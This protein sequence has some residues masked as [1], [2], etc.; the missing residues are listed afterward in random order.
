MVVG[1]C[2]QSKVIALEGL[3]SE[4]RRNEDEYVTYLLLG[5][6]RAEAA[7][8]HFRRALS[9]L[10]KPAIGSIGAMGLVWR[11]GM[12]TGQNLGG[13]DPW[14]AVKCPIAIM[15]SVFTSITPTN[16]LGLWLG[17]RVAFDDLDVLRQA[18]YRVEKST[19]DARR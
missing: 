2:L 16:V 5:A 11:P 12:M 15:L 4:L 17:I 19:T 10:V 8:P 7:R 9:A 6:S 3:Y 1:N 14:L 18:I 13:S